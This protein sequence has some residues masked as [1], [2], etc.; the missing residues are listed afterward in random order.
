MPARRGAGGAAGAAGA[1]PPCGVSAP[2]GGV[3]TSRASIDPLSPPRNA[4]GDPPA[5]GSVSRRS[6]PPRLAGPR[7]QGARRARTIPACQWQRRAARRRRSAGRR[8]LPRRRRPAGQGA[9]RAHRVRRC[10]YPRTTSAPRSA[11]ASRPARQA[12]SI[13]QSAPS[14]SGRPPGSARSCCPSACCPLRPEPQPIGRS[15]PRFASTDCRC[16]PGA[17]K[18]RRCGIACHG[19]IAVSAR[20]GRMFPTR[21]CIAS[22]DDWLLPFLHGEASFAR[23]DPGAVHAGLMSL[24]PHDL[25][26]KIARARADP[27]RRAVGQPCADPL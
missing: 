27:F 3:R 25:Q 8:G 7:R 2:K 20:P 11:T 5:S 4:S 21:R 9:E 16:S 18:P 17:R 13:R 12:P 15:S 14:A 26:R 1:P 23:I 24:V 22:L 19:C 6:S 10:R